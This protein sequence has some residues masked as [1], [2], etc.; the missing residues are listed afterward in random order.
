MPVLLYY[1]FGGKPGAFLAFGLVDF[2]PE[3]SNALKLMEEQPCW[4]Y[5]FAHFALR[6]Y[7]IRRILPQF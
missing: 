7:R 6:A 1:C 5:F 4:C 2:I 3:I